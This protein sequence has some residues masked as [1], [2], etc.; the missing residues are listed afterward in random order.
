MFLVE[1]RALPTKN[2][3]AQP[4]D[5]LQPPQ[6]ERPTKPVEGE[7]LGVPPEAQTDKGRSNIFAKRSARVMLLDAP[8][9]CHLTKVPNTAH[10]SPS[11]LGI[12]KVFR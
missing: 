10:Q 6:M 3:I 7:T 12:W 4:Y 11:R 5:D 1:E 2:K 8:R 9:A